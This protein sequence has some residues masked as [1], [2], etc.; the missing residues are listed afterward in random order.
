MNIIIN[1]TIYDNDVQAKIYH[2]G[3]IETTLQDLLDNSTII[4]TGINPVILSIDNLNGDNHKYLLLLDNINNTSIYGFGKNII[5][6]DLIELGSNN[7][8]TKVYKALI[9]FN[10]IDEKVEVIQEFRNST[11]STF[12]YVYNGHGSAIIQSSDDNLALNICFPKIFNGDPNASLYDF[13]LTAGG[14]PSQLS[15]NIY[16]ELKQ[17]LSP[18]SVTPSSVYIELEIYD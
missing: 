12:T 15:I 17:P 5:E 1:K 16:D 7:I 6:S 18:S 4:I 11:G 13:T 14:G 2:I 9:S 3:Q 10:D 8:S